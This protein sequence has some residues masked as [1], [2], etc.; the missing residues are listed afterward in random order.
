[1]LF[2]FCVRET[3]WERP[4][5]EA[6][7]WQYAVLSQMGD[8]EWVWLLFACSS[9]LQFKIEMGQGVVASYGWFCWCCLELRWLPDYCTHFALGKWVFTLYSSSSLSKVI[10]R[11]PTS[12]AYWMCEVC[13]QGW[14][15]MIQSGGMLRLSTVLISFCWES[16][17]NNYTQTLRTSHIHDVWT[18]LQL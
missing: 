1:M 13:L 12:A 10:T 17:G 15:Y 8:D 2:C 16:S 18:K 3:E 9:N 14:A 7:T 6:T 11:T 4:G 5:N